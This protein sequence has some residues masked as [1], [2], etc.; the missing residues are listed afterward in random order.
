M[1]ARNGYFTYLV[2]S[3]TTL[4]VSSPAAQRYTSVLRAGC[5]PR[6]HA[7][8]FQACAIIPI[9]FRA[10]VS[11]QHTTKISSHHVIL[12]FIQSDQP[13]LSAPRD[14]QQL[15]IVSTREY[16]NVST[17]SYCVA[18]F[19]TDDACQ[20]HNLQTGKIMTPMGSFVLHPRLVN[21][22]SQKKLLQSRGLAA[23]FVTTRQ[24]TPVLHA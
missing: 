16:V 17:S 19:M 23:R 11:A 15:R 18:P 9:C 7:C 1:H 8:I 20:Y 14:S 6:L 2:P 10:H 4:L 24:S 12:K 5:G 3:R 22:G 21:T 13:C